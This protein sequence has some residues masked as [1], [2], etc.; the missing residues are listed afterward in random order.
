[1][2]TDW[3]TV[4]IVDVSAAICKYTVNI[5]IIFILCTIIIINLCVLYISNNS[6][7]SSIRLFYCYT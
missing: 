1:M 4:V 5:G 3:L 6:G 7:S 2:R